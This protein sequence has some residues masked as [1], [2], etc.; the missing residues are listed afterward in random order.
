MSFV[1]PHQQRT[2]TVPAGQSII[3]GN[4]HSS[5]IQLI[6]A[7]PGQPHG[8]VYT[9]PVTVSGDITGPY[10]R[11]TLVTLIN[12]GDRVEYVVGVS[13]VLTGA[14]GGGSPVTLTGI[15][16][17]GQPVAAMVAAGWTYDGVQWKRNTG[18]TIINATGGGSTTLVYTQVAADVIGGVKIYPEFTNLRYITTGLTAPGGATVTSVPSLTAPLIVGTLA[19]FTPAVFSDGLAPTATQFTLAGV[20]AGATYTPVLVDSNKI[21]RVRQLSAGG[22]AQ[23]LSAP[24]LV[25]WQNWKSSNTVAARAMMAASGIRGRIMVL[26]DSYPAGYGA[27]NNGYI[28][29]RARSFPSQL[30]TLLNAAGRSASASFACGTGRKNAAGQSSVT[31][32]ESDPRIVFANPGVNALNGFETLGGQMFRVL[33]TS[34]FTF[35]PGGVFEAIELQFAISSANA[36]SFNVSVDGGTTTLQ[37]VIDSAG[38]S[39]V[40]RA[41]IAAPPGSTAVTIS[42]Q[43]GTAGNCSMMIGTR[44]PSAPGI[45]IYNAGQTGAQM[46]VIAAAPGS[47]NN[48]NQWNTRACLPGLLDGAAPNLTIINGWYNDQTAGRTLSQIQADLATLI[49]TCKAYGDVMFINYAALDTASISN[50]N[51]RSFSDG[52]IAT[53]LGLDIPVLDTSRQMNYAANAALFYDSLHL[54]DPG[55]GYVGGSLAARLLAP[56]V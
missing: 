52:C 56:L 37:N 47:A 30:A 28:N 26:G 39:S 8:P 5:Y 2:V 55:H 49:T 43:A 38:V 41:T 24:G 11:D 21:I 32:N 23:A 33:G 34:K 17:L 18:G 45:E 25:G 54:Q 14:D 29:M 27:D 6:C 22:T 42:A 44:T 19:A 3:I 35:T 48:A 10:T 46:Q 13:P 9:V 51:F 36:G 53:A 50:T 16:G 4:I 7:D 12:G 40:G 31:I 20:D 1:F 15:S